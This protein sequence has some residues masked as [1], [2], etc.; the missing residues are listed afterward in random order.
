LAGCNQRSVTPRQRIFVNDRDRSVNDTG[1]H[2]TLRR[3]RAHLLHPRTLAMLALVGCALTLL[4]PF[5]TDR[6]LPPV[7]RAL[8]WIGIVFGTYA[9]GTATDLL[10][11]PRCA[12]LSAGMRLAAIAAATGLS[13]GVTV[14]LVTGLLFGWPDTWLG[15]LSDFATVVALGVLASL[16]VQIA[17][18]PRPGP[19]MPTAPTHPP[20]FDRLPLDKRGRLV[21]L[22]VED[23]DVQV[24]TDKGEAMIL[25]RLGDAIREAAPIPGLRV[26]RSHWVARDAVRA[27]RR[28]GD[29][30]ILTMSHGGDIPASRSHIGA[31]KHAGLL[32][33]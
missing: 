12:A 18:T 3:L 23:H 28:E 16:G 17:T 31:L 26:H 10:L 5:N 20:L 7:G 8:F 14:D 11:R 21:A 27:V 30:A 29:R 4:A 22:S 33:R 1:P 2:S 6:A 9:V 24:R 25:M 15:T 13:T 19:A 32:P